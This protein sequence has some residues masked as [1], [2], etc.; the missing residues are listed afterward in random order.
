MS[1]DLEIFVCIKPLIF[2]M[3]QQNGRFISEDGKIEIG[4][5]IYRDSIRLPGDGVILWYKFSTDYD[6]SKSLY[7]NKTFCDW[8]FKDHFVPISEYSSIKL[9]SMK[10]KKLKIG[11][12]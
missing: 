5:F 12:F 6:N 8:N 2:D 3:Y 4:R 9:R 10:L 11:K 7:W 1:E